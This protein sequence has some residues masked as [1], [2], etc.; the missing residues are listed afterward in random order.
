MLNNN[1]VTKQFVQFIKCDDELV[2]LY[3][4]AFPQRVNNFANDTSFIRNL[5]YSKIFEIGYDLKGDL[6]LYCAILRN[7]LIESEELDEA[8]EKI[9]WKFRNVIPEDQF[10]SCS[11]TSSG[12]R[13]KKK[14]KKLLLIRKKSCCVKSAIY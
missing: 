2:M 3:L 14:Y 5:W 9:V 7:G 6:K 8:N 12:I 13:R 1:K 10:S 11:V 4:R